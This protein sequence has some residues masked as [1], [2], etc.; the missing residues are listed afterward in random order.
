MIATMTYEEF[1]R[2]LG[3]AGI[4]AREFGEALKLHPKS[5]TNYS[6]QGEVPTHLA[7]IVSLMGEMAEHGLDYRAVLARIHIEP[8]KPRGGA[9]K[10]RFGGTKQIELQLSSS[11]QGQS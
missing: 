2:Q 4:T 9:T 7:V 1:R 6:K 11:T 10:G 8:N 5:I 3:K